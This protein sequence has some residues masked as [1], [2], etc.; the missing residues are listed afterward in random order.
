M[1]LRVHLKPIRI[2]KIKSQVIAHAGE[3]VEQ[4]EHSIAGESVNLYSHSGN[5]F[6]SNSEN[7]N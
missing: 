6:G 3:D 7:R 2:A 5:Q 1:I 4:E